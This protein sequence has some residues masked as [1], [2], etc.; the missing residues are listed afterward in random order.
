VSTTIRDHPHSNGDPRHRFERRE[1]K[2]LSQTNSCSKCG[3]ALS[4]RNADCTYC[5]AAVPRAAP[6]DPRSPTVIAARLAAVRGHPDFDALWRR[7][8]STEAAERPLRR[9]AASG[10]AFA[11]VATFILVV[12]CGIAG[13]LTGVWG[14]MAREFGGGGRARS[15][16]GGTLAFEAMIVV[17]VGVVALFIVIGVKIA[18][19]SRGKV[20]R[21]RRAR[22]ERYPAY[23]TGERTLVTGGSG[24]SPAATTY[25]A[26]LQFEDGS[27]MEFPVDCRMAGAVDAGDVGV[28]YVQGGY[29]IDFVRLDV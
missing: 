8:P 24:D 3:A 18:T 9:V 19:G 5:G 22:L 21:L 26:T 20:R 14:F 16:P 11:A 12:F 4:A 27:R 13:V 10:V 25:H 29:L 17:F 7:T 2:R 23:V 6:V 1:V 28:A 15:L